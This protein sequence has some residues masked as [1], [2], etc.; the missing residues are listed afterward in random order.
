MIA[1][2]YD[3]IEISTRQLKTIPMLEIKGDYY[4]GPGMF[5]YDVRAIGTVKS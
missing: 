2:I 4:T 5:R 1:F 3:R